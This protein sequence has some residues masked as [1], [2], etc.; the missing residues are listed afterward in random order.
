MARVDYYA[1]EN[2]IAAV[3]RADATLA[4]VTVMVEEE[5]SFQRGSIVGIYLDDRSSPQDLQA[6]SAGT[7]TRFIVNFT[8]W[9]WHMGI[10]RD[11]TMV[12]QQRDDLVGKVEIAL[13][14]NRTLSNTVNMSWL[15]GG[16]FISGPDPQGNQFMSGAEI[17][18][19]ADVTAST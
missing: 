15:E 7:E 2:A 8:V 5:L 4:G 17:K 13:M 1:I 10:G 14:K 16:E 9:C 6:I 11:R 12:M 3:L 18:L 19:S